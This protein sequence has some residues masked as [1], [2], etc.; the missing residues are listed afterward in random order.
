[1]QTNSVRFLDFAA[2]YDA[3]AISDNTN[4]DL[5]T[6]AFM[7]KMPDC[8]SEERAVQYLGPDVEGE[9]DVLLFNVKY[10][11]KQITWQGQN[12]EMVGLDLRKTDLA[13]M[14]LSCFKPAFFIACNALTGEAMTQG[15]LQV[16]NSNKTRINHG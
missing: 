10:H 12:G 11:D 6:I 14:P 5:S 1:M 2:L 4:P 7:I 8:G 3:Q 13:N 15:A 9:E 16:T